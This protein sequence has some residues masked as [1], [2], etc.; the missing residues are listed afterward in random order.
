MCRENRITARKVHNMWLIDI[1][2]LM[3]FAENYN[4][5]RRGKGKNGIMMLF[6]GGYCYERS[7]SN[8]EM[9]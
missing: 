5:P 7:K 4:E 2:D 1:A 3:K 8:R 9:G 6:S